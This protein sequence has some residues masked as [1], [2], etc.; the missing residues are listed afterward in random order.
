MNKEEFLKLAQE[1]MGTQ[2]NEANWIY[3]FENW[4]KEQLD[5]QIKVLEGLIKR[6]KK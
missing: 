4:T 6:R 3:G 1:A 2:Y 5:N